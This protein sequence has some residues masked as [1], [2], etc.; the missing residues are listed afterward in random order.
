M[1]G[2]TE[3]TKCPDAA[4]VGIV[5]V[6]EVA[7]HVLTVTGDAF[8]VTKLLP[9]LDPKPEP[10]ITIWLPMGPVVAETP[11]IAGAGKA[12]ELTET[13]SKVEIPNVEPLF[14]PAQTIP[15]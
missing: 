13:L 1:L 11:V 9:W 15:M 7:L 10:V 3:T 2:A 4:P 8:S 6:I 14:C 5:M 12:D